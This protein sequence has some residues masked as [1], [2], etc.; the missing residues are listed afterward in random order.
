LGGIARVIA[1]IADGRPNTL[2]IVLLAFEVLLPPSILL[3]QR[4]ILEDL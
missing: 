2:F 3:L 4:S 1:W